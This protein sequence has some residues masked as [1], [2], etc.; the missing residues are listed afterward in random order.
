M[1]ALAVCLAACC[2]RHRP[3]PKPK[4]AALPV[5]LGLSV[6]WADRNVGATEAEGIGIYVAWGET[7]EKEDY[8]L[9]TYRFYSPT[10]GGIYF[11][12]KA[13]DVLKPENDAASSVM[14][15]EWRMPTKEEWVEL[16]DKCTWTWVSEEGRSGYTVTGIGGGSIFLPAA[17]VREGTGD[18]NA[19]AFSFSQNSYSLIYIDRPSGFQIRAVRARKDKGE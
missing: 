19:W 3:E 17:G 1:A 13:G 9:A 7:S 4:P 8:S 15:E 6:E 2:D 11:D 14:G 18:E 12:Y 16:V 5:E 10:N